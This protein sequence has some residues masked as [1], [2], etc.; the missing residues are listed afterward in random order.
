[1]SIKW[2]T[3]SWNLATTAGR[4]VR[5]QRV[6]ST[7]WETQYSKRSFVLSSIERHKWS[8]L[9]GRNLDSKDSSALDQEACRNEGAINNF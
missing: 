5:R 4:S 8:A 9:G 2:D 3:V 7:K 6:G 1:M